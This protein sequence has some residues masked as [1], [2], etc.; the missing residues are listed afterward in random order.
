[1][2][3]K[4]TQKKIAIDRIIQNIL[5][6]KKIYDYF[7]TIFHTLNFIQDVHGEK[8]K[9]SIMIFGQ[10]HNKNRMKLSYQMIVWKGN[11]TT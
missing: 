9:F 1:M 3:L 11:K 2:D 8:I 4:S 10:T 7:Y 5:S 6:L